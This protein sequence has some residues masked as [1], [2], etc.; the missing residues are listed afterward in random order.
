M[1]FR[2]RG[3]SSGIEKGQ[4]YGE[5]EFWALM[6]HGADH[7][8]TELLSLDRSTARWVANERELSPHVGHCPLSTAAVNRFL[9]M[10]GARIERGLLIPPRF[11]DGAIHVPFDPNVPSL[12]VTIGKKA[13]RGISEIIAELD[14][15]RW[16]QRLGGLFA[17]DLSESP[18]TLSLKISAP[19]NVDRP[20][21]SKVPVVFHALYLLP[22]WL[23]PSGEHWHSELTGRY[24]KFLK[25]L[26]SS[27]AQ[28]DPWPALREAMGGC[29]LA[30][31]DRA[32]LDGRRQGDISNFLRREVLGRRVTRSARGVIIPDPALRVD[33]VRIPAFAGD[34]LFSGLGKQA[35]R[36]V[37]VNR[38]P[39]LHRR[40]L[41]AMRPVVDYSNV[42]VFGLPL[43]VLKGMGADFDGDQVSIVAL[44]REASLAEAERLLPGSRDL[45]LDPFRNGSPMF[46]I[47]GE[48]AN[49]AEDAQLAIDSASLDEVPWCEARATA[50]RARIER[51]GDGWELLTKGPEWQNLAKEHARLWTGSISEAE[52]L[53]R[54]KTEMEHV[55][56]GVRRKGRFGGILRRQ[57]YLRSFSNAPTFFKSVDALSSITER[58]VQ[59][60]LSVKSDRIDLSTNEINAFFERPDPDFLKRL[61][62]SFNPVEVLGALG[63]GVRLPSLGAFLARPTLGTILSLAINGEGSSLEVDDPRWSWF[64]S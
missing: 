24:W 9:S 57:L 44:E 13:I 42:P 8:A 1:S 43:A 6:A 16:Y 52:W 39:T 62:A 26:A 7:I 40:S 3:S 12:K 2:V 55:Y 49:M 61:D 15:E 31:L 36:I 27:W 45:R 21:Q 35:R 48:F 58:I 50:E 38:N 22:P 63:S 64:L 60:A 11:S 54:A 32:E 51:I 46:S 4:R 59:K 53:E 28:A 29:V 47:A 10:I 41:L 25:L 33:Q 30:A 14:N 20:H 19:P 5:M 23:R 56:L 17:L 18:I 34:E 37:L